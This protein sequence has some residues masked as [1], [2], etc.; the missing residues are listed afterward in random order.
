M[1]VVVTPGQLTD[2]NSDRRS[3]DDQNNSPRRSVTPSTPGDRLSITVK[4]FSIIKFSSYKQH[5]SL[6]YYFN[7]SLNT[8]E[9][10]LQTPVQSTVIKKPIHLC[11]LSR[12]SSNE[13]LPRK[14]VPT[15]ALQQC[16]G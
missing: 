7:F 16:V 14:T 5:S 9:T 11:I 13:F 10:Y 6:H 1:G 3:T 2:D 12:K 4:L 8:M 15:E